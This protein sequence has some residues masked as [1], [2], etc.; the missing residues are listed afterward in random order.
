MVL[1][2]GRLGQFRR[3]GLGR[4][5]HVRTVRAVG[6]GHGVHALRVHGHR[7]Q[8]GLAGLRDVALRVALG[9]V[10]LVAPPQ[11]QTAPV[12]G[13]PGRGRRQRGQ[14]AV[15]VATAREDHRRLAP[16]GLRVHDL[17]DQTGRGGLRHQFLVVMHDQLRSAHFAAA[18]FAG[19]FLAAA[20]FAGAL[21]TSA[22]AATAVSAS[23]TGC[24]AAA[25][26]PGFSRS[27]P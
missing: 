21:A 26:E 9:K 27:T 3:V 15:A 6:G 20:F 5:L 13:V 25:S 19:A 11:V 14:Q 12:D 2:P 18:F 10:A 1:R 7:V 8:Q 23:A 16:G 24:G 17:R 22:A 4:G